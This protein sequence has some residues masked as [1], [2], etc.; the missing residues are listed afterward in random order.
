MDK[1]AVGTAYEKLAGAYLEQQGYRVI[2]YNFRCRGGEIDVIAWDG[3]YLV[4]VEVKYRR[5]AASGD[6]LEAVD[7]RKQRRISRAA[8]YY[9][10]THGYGESTPCRF[11]VAAVLGGQICVVKNA[12]EYAGD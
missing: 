10:L 4:F 9:C 1:R 11:D 8:V 5:T 7:F 6:P 2:E 12:F 3:E